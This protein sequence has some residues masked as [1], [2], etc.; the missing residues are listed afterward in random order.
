MEM[1]EL[2]ESR[3]IMGDKKVFFLTGPPCGGKTALCNRLDGNYFV[4]DAY[5]EIEVHKNPIEPLTANEITKILG[6]VILKNTDKR[7]VII[8][9]YPKCDDFMDKW[10]MEQN[11]RQGVTGLKMYH[12]GTIILETGD[13]RDSCDRRENFEKDLE[14]WN[15]FKPLLEEYDTTRKIK[16]FDEFE[17]TIDALFRVWEFDKFVHK[18]L[19]DEKIKSW[20][21][22]Q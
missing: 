4:V 18:T 16:S 8:D 14:E 11:G 19:E 3:G 6:D 22:Q 21:S 9:G 7:T 2:H 5:K 10:F 15:K 17:P 1:K 20:S 12:Y 13:E